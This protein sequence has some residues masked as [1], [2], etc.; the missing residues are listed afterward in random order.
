MSAPKDKDYPTTVFTP[1]QPM[2]RPGQGPRFAQL[3]V[4]GCGLIGASF[5]LAAKQMGLVRQVVGYSRSPSTIDT[6]KRIGAIDAGAESALQAVSG[7]DLV[8]LAAPV[9]ATGAL[10]KTIAS[11][12]SPRS[13]IMDVGSTKRDVVKAAAD[14]PSLARQF[15]P[16]HPIAGK[17]QSGPEA[18]DPTLF[19]GKKVILCPLDG[20]DMATIDRAMSVW[21]SVGAEPLEMTAEDHDACF[22]AVSHLP[23][24]LAFAYMNAISRQPHSARALELAGSGFADFSRIAGSSPEMWRDILLANRDELLLQLQL[25]K[26]HLGPLEHALQAEDGA[27]LLAL[28]ERAS[29]ARRLWAEQHLAPSASDE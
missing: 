6:A 29:V 13:L 15:V 22:A 21:E 11:L 3:A 16:A 23:H 1:T 20:N 17:H 28:M 10:L 7:A 25:F 2:S 19:V 14:V 27:A 4:L 26:Q 24:L 18:A 9:S 8:L 12:V 5:A